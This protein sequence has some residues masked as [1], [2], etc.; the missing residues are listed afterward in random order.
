MDDLLVSSKLAIAGMKA[1][2]KRLRVI[3][4]NLANA[5]SVASTPGGNPYQRKVVTFQNVLNEEIGADMVEIG[6]IEKDKTAFPKEFDPANPAAG[7]D[8]Y[9]KLP[10][11]NPLIEMM[12]MKEAQ[13]SYEANLRTIE[14]SRSMM[15]D[16]INLLKD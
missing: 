13:R 2:A 11:V 1:Q 5:D 12:D 10:N 7:L 6:S 9:V 16:T 14:S 4:E 3:S 15:K 8:G